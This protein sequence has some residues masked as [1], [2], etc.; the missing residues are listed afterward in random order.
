MAI[1]TIDLALGATS[2]LSAP[3]PAALPATPDRLDATLRWRARW[4]LRRLSPRTSHALRLV[5]VL[6]QTSVPTQSLRGEPPGVE[7]LKLH[8]SALQHIRAFDLPAPVA[9]QRGRRVVSAVVARLS[10]SGDPELLVFPIPD[11]GSA[12][13]E[14]LRE[15]LEKV[16][17]FLREQKLSFPLA[18]A[19]QGD[20]RGGS[21]LVASIVAFGALIAGR[22]PKETWAGPDKPLAPQVI[23]RLLERAPTPLCAAAL[24][25]MLAE[26][27]PSP[28]AA[29]KSALASASAASL[30]D[31]DRFAA[32]WVSLAG[33]HG[34]LISRVLSLCRSGA[35]G[36]AEPGGLCPFPSEILDAGRALAM[37]AAAS[38]R[39]TDREVRQRTQPLL[40]R[41]FI[42]DGVPT[43]LL[44]ALAAAFR[45]VVG[46][47][48]GAPIA[49][50][51]AGPHAF[52]TFDASGAALSRGRTADQALVR[53]LAPLARAGEVIKLEDTRW[54]IL[55][56]RLAQPRGAG[57]LLLAVEHLPQD[58]EPNDPLNRGRTRQFSM[59][60]ALSL[61]LRAKGRPSA[62]MLEPLQAVRAVVVQAARGARVE[63]VAASA[64]AQ[65][66][67]GRL[68]RLAQLAAAR[69]AETERPL[70]VEGGGHVISL[71]RPGGRCYPLHRFAARP[72][73]CTADP[74]APDLSPW[75]ED[76][77]RS[78]S[79]VG[80][81][82]ITC[83]VSR[84]GKDHAS[85][86]YVDPQGWQLHEEVPLF[87][88]EEYLSDTREVLRA[89]P[90]PMLMSVRYAR[91]LELGLNHF[92]ARGS[93]LRIELAVEGR[94][95]YGLRVGCLGERFGSGTPLGWGAAA[96]AVLSAWPSG[97]EGL[98]C[99]RVVAV[100]D[101]GG[102]A[103]VGLLRLYAR[104]VVFRR[105]RLQTGKM[106]RA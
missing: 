21:E 4:L 60:E 64:A 47:R 63:V 7:A 8:T 13:L 19:S 43:V 106:C 95:P 88:L 6:L 99:C 58:G 80:G 96:Q 103:A 36:S 61:S 72:R 92:T 73:R 25:L 68:S 46:M 9:L 34:P 35:E 70:A 67:S 22:L 18:L 50:R 66:V 5:P 28:C 26:G 81:Q 24:V 15:R 10:A 105:L 75:S 86:L 17:R 65:A 100:S 3:E 30:A 59:D 79:A 32:H 2:P 51:R 41:D 62:R 77:A 11:I 83:H 27:A 74:E 85:V 48:R 93:E 69:G 91:E 71:S 53:A 84:L 54:R 1:R 42:G 55:A 56:P 49:V 78:A 102:A 98:L 38:V 40:W 76:K 39:A 23:S 104:S 14:R 12:E 101:G 29:L 33:T 52:E 90:A 94:L 31:P 57:V 97:T 37:A 45:S 89:A 20:A 16:E 82:M 87:G 44:P